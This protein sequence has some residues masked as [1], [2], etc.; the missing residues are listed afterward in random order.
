MARSYK[1]LFG[2]GT[3]LAASVAL[4]G[5]YMTSDPVVQKGDAMPWGDNAVCTLDGKN[6]ALDFTKPEKDA[7][8]GTVYK[9]NGEEYTFK[10]IEDDLYLVQLKG[11]GGYRY[12][13]LFNQGQ[14]GTR[15][16]SFPQEPGQG[17][18][19]LAREADVMLSRSKTIEGWT[20]MDARKP[21]DI[22]KF[23][24]SVKIGDLKPAG[25]CSFTKAPAKDAVILGPLRRNMLR[26]DV[27]ALKGAEECSLADVC[28]DL[29]EGG[30][31]AG[32]GGNG[33]KG[34]VTVSFTEEGISRV[35]TQING[36]SVDALTDKTN[37]VGS[38]SGG[39]NMSDSIPVL[40]GINS[41]D[42][43]FTNPE[44]IRSGPQAEKRARDAIAKLDGLSKG[45]KEFFG[46]PDFR[47]IRLIFAPKSSV[48]R[49]A[50]VKGY[51]QAIAKMEDAKVPFQDFGITKTEKGLYDMHV[52]IQP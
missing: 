11:K 23:L 48:V 13:Y 1:H 35:E 20:E 12:G 42:L 17:L 52:V 34:T 33:A 25:E 7:A 22:E 6:Y 4:S 28:F 3:V 30:F 38:I 41:V 36:L 51:Q 32:L 31:A 49:A 18:A 50:G 45:G 37:G 39:P 15:I 21:T 27:L 43:D 44:S 29:V 46:A 10:R 24:T 26:D 9:R 5:C 40:F 47:R 8:G 14:K 19:N 2:L 16:L